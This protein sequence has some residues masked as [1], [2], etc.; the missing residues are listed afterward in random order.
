MIS[1]LL[2]F[3]YIYITGTDDENST[4]ALST[5]AP[6]TTREPSVIEIDDEDSNK[7]AAEET[8]EEELGMYH[9]LF[10]CIFS[11]THAI[12]LQNERRKP[13]ALLSMGFSMVMLRLASRAVGPSISSSAL[14]YTAESRV[15]EFGDIRTHKIMLPPQT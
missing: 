11:V 9:D 7:S 14:P 2:K 1:S 3:S 6:S 8:P 5:R 13:G 12:V 10:S 4:R 15:V